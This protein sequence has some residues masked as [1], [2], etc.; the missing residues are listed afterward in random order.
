[1]VA[2]LRGGRRR[3]PPAPEGRWPGA[4]WLRRLRWRASGY[5]ARAWAFGPY[6]WARGSAPAFGTWAWWCRA[7]VAARCPTPRLGL[8][9]A[10]APP[11]RRA[12]VGPAWSNPTR[13]PADESSPEAS[14]PCLDAA[15]PEPPAS[16][17]HYLE[18][19][20]AAPPAT[21]WTRGTG[22][23]RGT[24]PAASEATSCATTA[25]CWPTTQTG[26]PLDTCAQ[27]VRR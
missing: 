11:L 24:P 23:A 22:P 5:C 20:G 12:A 17:L 4:S 9:V 25:S 8:G 1:M 16:A 15:D 27:I 13:G 19:A 6:A 21:C 18:V 10:A 2:Y 7:V 26:T 3:G 14:A